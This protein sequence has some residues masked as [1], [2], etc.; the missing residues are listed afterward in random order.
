MVAHENQIGEESPRILW[1]P[2][3]SA[4]SSEPSRDQP[5][6]TSKTIASGKSPSR[7]IDPGS[8]A[9]LVGV[10]ENGTGVGSGVAV[11]A[12]VGSPPTPPVR[13]NRLTAT[14]AATTT[15]AAPNANR[16]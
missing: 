16:A 5:A 10:D 6:G 8:S 12:A 3:R 2:T 15:A 1:T 11:G 4:S 14:S 13:G 7:T 9:P